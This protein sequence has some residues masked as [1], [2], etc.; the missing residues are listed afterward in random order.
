MDKQTEVVESESGN[1][2]DESKTY[3]ER[4]LDLPNF[5]SDSIKKSEVAKYLDILERKRS[6]VEQRISSLADREKALKELENTIQRKISNL[7]EEKRFFAES[8]QKEKEMKQE[9]LTDLISF[10]QKMGPKKAA[11]VFEKMDKDLVVKLFKNM[12]VKQTTS[13]LQLMNPDRSVELTEYYGR[14]KSGKEYDLLKEV[15]Q[16]LVEEFKE[17]CQDNKSSSLSSTAH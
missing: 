17:K 16:S 14:L 3:L 1:K 8:I 2:S 5:E 13:I 6:Q 15:N 10:Y 11:P 7:E 4:L 12:P 9:R